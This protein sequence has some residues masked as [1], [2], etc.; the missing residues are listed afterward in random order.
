MNVL[1]IDDSLSACRSVGRI[2]MDE[3]TTI[4]C[5]NGQEWVDYYTRS[6]PDIILLD[7]VMPGINGIDVLKQIR[8]IDK[9]IPVVM[10][11]AIDTSDKIMDCIKLGANGYVAKPISAD[12][13]IKSVQ[14]AR[15]INAIKNLNVGMAAALAKLQEGV[16]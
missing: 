2:L 6:K 11:S 13:I 15:R 1:V 3:A 9:D 14:T 16:I 5:L 8:E 12:R 7:I 4:C 10:V